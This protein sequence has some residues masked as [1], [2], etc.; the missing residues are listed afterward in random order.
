MHCSNLAAGAFHVA[1]REYRKACAGAP[2]EL[3]G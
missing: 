2:G 1:I 3:H